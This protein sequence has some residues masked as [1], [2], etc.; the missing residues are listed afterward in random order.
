MEQE[1]RSRREDSV[2]RRGQGGRSATVAEGEEYI[3]LLT[4]KI[5]KLG[6]FHNQQLFPSRTPQ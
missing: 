2:R 3:I 1:G 4:Y 6:Y 5:L